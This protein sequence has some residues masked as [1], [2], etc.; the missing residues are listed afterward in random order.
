M[1]RKAGSLTG[2][3]AALLFAA[4]NLRA[5]RERE[6]FGLQIA[7]LLEDADGSYRSTGYSSLYRALDRL[8]DQGLLQ[9]RLEPAEL[10]EEARR[11]RRRLYCV[12]GEGARAHLEAAR[13]PV[14]PRFVP[15]L[16]PG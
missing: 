10:A 4:L 2:L 7:K 9:S 5:N 13:V 12:T 1:R 15:R 11:P 14:S 3:E 8:E 6:F 16:L